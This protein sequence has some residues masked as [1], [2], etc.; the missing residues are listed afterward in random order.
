MEEAI[1][2]FQTDAFSV[3]TPRFGIRLQERAPGTEMPQAF[4][5]LPSPWEKAP[6]ASRQNR[7]M[8]ELGLFAAHLSAEVV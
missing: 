5:H 8:G 4:S 7:Q 1:L 3:E 6:I 2:K